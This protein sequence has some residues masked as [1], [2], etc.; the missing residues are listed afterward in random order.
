MIIKVKGRG[1]VGGPAAGC[2]GG[3]MERTPFSPPDSE[4]TPRPPAEQFQSQQQVQ[5]EVIPAPTPG[6]QR[7]VCARAGLV[8]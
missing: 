3:E 7:R 2:W 8:P 1:G 4:V 6:R 5:Q